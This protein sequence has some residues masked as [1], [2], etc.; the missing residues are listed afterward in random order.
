LLV[1]AIERHD[2]KRFQTIAVSYGPDTTD[3]MRE[4]I[5]GAAETFIDVRAK[6]D[7]DTARALRDIEVDIAVDLTGFT[8]FGRLGI[9]CCPSKIGHV[10]P[11]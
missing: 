2:R 11:V 7:L 6:S 8:Q 5:R 10:L 3:Q 4:R 9:C 1:E